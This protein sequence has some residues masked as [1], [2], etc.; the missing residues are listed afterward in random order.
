MSQPHVHIVDESYPADCIAYRNI[1]DARQKQYRVKGYKADMDKKVEVAVQE[2]KTKP[3]SLEL[4][5]YTNKA[6]II[7][8]PSQHTEPSQIID[9]SP[10]KNVVTEAGEESRGGMEKEQDVLDEAIEQA[11]QQQD[12]VCD[13]NKT[14]Y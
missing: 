8:T 1:I 2:T 4:K 10:L 7:Q 12:L 5:P 14:I 11:K 9:T 6:V 3:Q 13:I